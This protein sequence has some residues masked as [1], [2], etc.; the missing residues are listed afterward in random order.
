M[1]VVLC[2]LLQCQ[3][4]PL[5]FG[6]ALGVCPQLYHQFI[7]WVSH[8]VCM[9]PFLHPCGGQDTSVCARHIVPLC[10]WTGRQTLQCLWHRAGLW[11]Q[12]RNSCSEELSISILFSYWNWVHL[13]KQNLSVWQKICKGH[14][15]WLG[16][17]GSLQSCLGFETSSSEPELSWHH[18]LYSPVKQ[19]LFS[20][21]DPQAPDHPLPRFPFQSLF[22]L[23]YFTTWATKKNTRDTLL[24]DTGHSSASPGKF[25]ISMYSAGWSCPFTM[26]TSVMGRKTALEYHYK[27]CSHPACTAKCQLAAPLLG[28]SCT[29][30]HPAL[31]PGSSKGLCGN[32]S[33]RQPLTALGWRTQME[34]LLVSI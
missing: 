17:Q 20:L 19:K 7:Q 11:L 12:S 5:Y 27:P 21:E 18:D 24:G 4:S 8:F 25:R 26:T 9:S 31:F 3:S 6:S 22:K 15:Q 13:K 14:S 33:D 28:F 32:S 2:E 30:F 34:N 16:C 29:P 23:C 1:A 10:W